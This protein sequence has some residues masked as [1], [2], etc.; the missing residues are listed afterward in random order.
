MTGKKGDPFPSQTV[1]EDQDTEDTELLLL[2]SSLFL[3]YKLGH[4]AKG[5]KG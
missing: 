2:K 5:Q 1:L 3:C 4:K